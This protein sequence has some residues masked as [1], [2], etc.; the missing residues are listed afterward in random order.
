MKTPDSVNRRSFL[1]TSAQAAAAWSLGACPLAAAP[2]RVIALRTRQSRA[3]AASSTGLL[4]VASD[5]AI[6]FF[7]LDGQLRREVVTPRPVRAVAFDRADRLFATYADQVARVEASGELTP[8]GESRGRESALTGLAIAENG[9]IFAADSGGRVVWRL[10]ASGRV[11]GT[12]QPVAGT[13][14]VPRAFFPIAWSGGLL[15]VGDPGRHQVQSYTA[16]G[17]P[18]A[19]WGVRSRDAEGFSGCCNPVS[20]AARADGTVIT[21]ERGQRRVK[22]FDA[23]GRMA[24]VLAGPEQ[25]APR[26][27]PDAAEGD[28]AACDGGLLDVAIG[29]RGE[30]ILLDRTAREIRVL[31]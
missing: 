8:L 16:D 12:I 23:A 18:V 5:N 7:D 4:A 20:L 31:A 15:L 19:K 26:T 25:F 13:F 29:P 28:V 14:S 10:D 3:I 24:R 27:E 17:V 22:V 2:A 6:Q 21:A 11:L 30:V 9:G 1:F